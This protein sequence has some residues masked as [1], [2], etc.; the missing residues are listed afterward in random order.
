MKILSV[1]TLTKCI[2]VRIKIIHNFSTISTNQMTVTNQKIPI[3]ANFGPIDT[4]TLYRVLIAACIFA[5]KLTGRAIVFKVIIVTAMKPWT[6]VCRKPP[7]PQFDHF[8]PPFQSD[9]YIRHGPYNQDIAY[10]DHVSLD[11]VIGWKA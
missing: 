5:A 9:Q 8:K 7:N 10:V 3:N 4:G 6:I 11:Y 1:A 2:T